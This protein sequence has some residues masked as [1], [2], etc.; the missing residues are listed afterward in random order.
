MP[1]KISFVALVFSLTLISCSYQFVEPPFEDSRLVKV[2]ETRFGEELLSA[3]ND[4]PNTDQTAGIKEG[5]GEDS[6]VLDVSEDFLIQQEFDEEKGAWGLTVITKN[7]HHMMFCSLIQRDD[8]EDG[9]VDIQFPENIEAKKDEGGEI[10]LSG[11]KV[12]IAQFAL[13]LSLSSPKLCLAVPY[14]DA[15][16]VATEGPVGKIVEKEVLV[17]V[18]V[19][20]E[21]IKEV[22][23]EVPVEVIVEKEVIKEVIKEVPVEVIVE[24]KVIKEVVKEV[25]IEVIVEKESSSACNN[26][27]SVSAITGATNSLMLFGPLLL[28]ASYG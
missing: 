28:V 5:L 23:K 18:I 20:K 21:V 7:R 11:D 8:D 14:Q 26:A 10:W 9:E 22:V 25:P 6:L 19:E 17:E 12:A 1:V 2:T 16:K 3:L 15:S 27:S 24:K 4:L 13:E